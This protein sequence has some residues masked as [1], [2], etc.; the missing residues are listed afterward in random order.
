MRVFFFQQRR[1]FRWECGTMEHVHAGMLWA[2]R[3]SVN[4]MNEKARLEFPLWCMQGFFG[5]A[6]MSACMR[7]ED[8]SNY[9]IVYE[10]ITYVA[11]INFQ[12]WLFVHSEQVDCTSSYLDTKKSATTSRKNQVKICFN[13]SRDNLWTEPTTRVYMHH[14]KKAAQLCWDTE[15][16]RH[17]LVI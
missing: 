16:Y 10:L 6:R 15:L 9:R 4:G 3:M 7:L 8:C 14:P 11:T 1:A 13:R 2:L 12:L 17:I 5:R